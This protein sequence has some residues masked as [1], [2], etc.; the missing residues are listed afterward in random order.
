VAL[1]VTFS[2]GAGGMLTATALRPGGAGAST[3]LP[4]EE[5]VDAERDYADRRGYDPEFLGVGDLEV[6]LP[7]LSDALVADAA[8]SRS[9]TAEPRHILPYHHFSVVMS[10]S[11]RL[12]RVTAVNIDGAG[13]RRIER[14]P[15]R[16]RVDPR[17][18]S[19][20][21]TDD[22]VYARNP[23]DRGHLVRR[24]DP[25]WGEGPIAERA[26]E[27]TFHFT[28]CAPQHEQ[29]NRTTWSDLEDYLLDHAQNLGFKASI[30]TGP[31]LAADDDPY[32]GVSLPRE[33][34]KVAVMVK[35][36]GRLSAT[37][38]MLSQ[39][40]LLA[41]LEAGTAF[42]YAAYRTYQVS[43]ATIESV[44]GL[45]FGTLARADPMGGP[46]ATSK[47]HEVEGPGD[48]VL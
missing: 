22:Q 10:A 30:F 4:G 45:S 36:P 5:A 37:G 20:E 8:L 12:A 39:A 27:D 6:P 15:D 33:F 48:L 21:Q 17:I 41:G 44:T 29:L 40:D 42:S 23:L 1:E 13:G 26:M 47:G 7:D 32:R 31:V 16:W 25:A 34:W 35:T 14:A 19:D 24:L 9:A 2:L 18:A 28:N 46:E 11:R 38:D 3:I 43:L